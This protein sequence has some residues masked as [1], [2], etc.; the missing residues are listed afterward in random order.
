MELSQGKIFTKPQP[1]MYLATLVD[2]VDMPNV[3]TAFGIKN[4]I[5]FHWVLSH[6]TGQ[7]Y[8][9]KDGTPVEAVAIFTASMGAK[10]ELPKRLTQILGQAP[11][12]ITST[13]QLEALV[14]GRSNLLVLVANAN[15]KNPNDPFI[16]VD[17]IGPIQ[18]GMP[19]APP[20][21]AN[22]VRFKNRPKTQAGPQGQ[23]VQ[24]FASPQA[25]QF[26]QPA[27]AA[28]PTQAWPGYA[29]P[30]APQALQQPSNTVNLNAGQP[31]QPPRDPNRPF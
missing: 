21:P 4:K 7:P 1:G 30:A 5:R 19:A 29:A 9:D 28:A 26:A 20:I 13:D 2:M 16:N 31:G 23:P 27:P 10:A 12:V 17:G 18:P 6:L 14:I 15:P 22:Y 11:P 24:T 8:I 25:A 3:Q